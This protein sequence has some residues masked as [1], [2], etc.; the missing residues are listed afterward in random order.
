MPTYVHLSNLTGH[1]VQN[2]EDSPE[3]LADGEELAASL[4]G[5]IKHFYLTFGRYDFVTVTEFPD[6]EAAA[7]FVLRVSGAG[8]IE[9][10]TLKAFPE[11]EYRDVIDGLP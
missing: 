6:D 3:R 9:M 4:G 1:G 8:A 11:D 10:E 7:Q 5:E 2:I